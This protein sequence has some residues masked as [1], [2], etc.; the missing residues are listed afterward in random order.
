MA[1]PRWKRR[2]P[3]SARARIVGWMVLLVGLALAVSVGLSWRVLL[4][5]VDERAN[6]E[7]VHESRKLRTFASSA[8]DQRGN[9]YRKGDALLKR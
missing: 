9:P 4:A 8:T 2:A 3:V 1:G 7:L 5:R 6:A